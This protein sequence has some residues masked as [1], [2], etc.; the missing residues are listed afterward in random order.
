MR[1]HL[2]H[3]FLAFPAF[4]IV[5]LGSMLTCPSP[6]GE[7]SDEWAGGWFVLSILWFAICCAREI[8]RNRKA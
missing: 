4:I 5:A 8:D 7:C 6:L 2:G 1:L 3:T